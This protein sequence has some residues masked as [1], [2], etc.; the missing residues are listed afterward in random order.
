MPSL[1]YCWY[2]LQLWIPS[3]GNTCQW[4]MELYP[5]EQTTS[6]KILRGRIPEHNLNLSRSEWRGPNPRQCTETHERHSTHITQLKCLCPRMGTIRCKTINL[7]Q[8]NWRAFEYRRETGCRYEKQELIDCRSLSWQPSSEK[9]MAAWKVNNMKT[10]TNT[11]RRKGPV[12]NW[13]KY[14]RAFQL[15]GKIEWP[16]NTTELKLQY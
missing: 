16:N 8:R 2:S 14:T 12:K 1:I 6:S 10:S 15:V 9:T 3:S 13:V 11:T 5:S 7:T 4:N